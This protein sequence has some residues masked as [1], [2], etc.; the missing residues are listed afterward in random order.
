VERVTSVRGHGDGD[1]DREPAELAA[2]ASS[3]VLCDQE[4]GASPA[5]RSVHPVRSGERI[6]SSDGFNES[7]LQLGPV[8][9]EDADKR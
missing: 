7:E 5:R 2:T 4:A 1:V 8:L 6:G 9:F 3:N